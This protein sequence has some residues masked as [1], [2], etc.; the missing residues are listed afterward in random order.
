MRY[1]NNKDINNRIKLLIRKNWKFQHGSKHARLIPPDGMHFITVSKS[2]SDY[3][4]F[5][6]FLSDVRRLNARHNP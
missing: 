4:S 3:R 1:T 2:P 6:N 5:Q